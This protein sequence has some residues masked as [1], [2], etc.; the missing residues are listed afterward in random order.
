MKKIAHHVVSDGHKTRFDTREIE[1]APVEDVAP[2]GVFDAA[3]LGEGAVALAR[4][5]S[6]FRCGFHNTATPTWMFIMT[7][8]MELGVS[9]GDTRTLAPGDVVYFTDSN[10]EG[11]RSRVLGDDDVIVATAGYVP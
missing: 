10:G 5:D 9:D 8:Q 1:L 11:H 6:G 4:F 7:G 3:A 2:G